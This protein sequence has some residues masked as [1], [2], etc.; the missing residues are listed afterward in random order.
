MFAAP[1][2]R[3]P[4]TLPMRSPP[5]ARS[6]AWPTASRTRP[7]NARCSTAGRGRRWPRRSE[8]RDRRSTRSTRAGFRR[9]ASAEEGADGVRAIHQGCA[10]RSG[11]RSRTGARAAATTTSRRSTAAGLA[12]RPEFQALGLDR[13]R[14][15]DA[16]AAEEE[17]SLA[18]VGVAGGELE[19]SVAARA[20]RKLQFATSAKLSLQRAMKVAAAARRP[21]RDRGARS[22]GRAR[23]R[24]R[25]GAARAAD[26]RDRCRR[27]CA[28]GSSGP[29][30]TPAPGRAPATRGQCSRTGACSVLAVGPC[31]S[32]VRRS[33]AVGGRPVRVQ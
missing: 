14:L 1:H 30:P 9:P 26:R 25:P 10:R 3:S 21:A 15:A 12:G 22:A 13:D 24:A 16:L 20:P 29:R 31:H 8:S 33:P 27:A 23:R 19:P 32:G 6:G 28:R 2:R 7:S 5:S 11:R 18:A 4:K 17:R